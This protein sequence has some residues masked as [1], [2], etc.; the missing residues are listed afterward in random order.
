MLCSSFAE[1][2]IMNICNLN[3]IT[4]KKKKKKTHLKISLIFIYYA[5]SKK[6]FV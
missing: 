4:I 1:R 6:T 3:S 2:E 5:V